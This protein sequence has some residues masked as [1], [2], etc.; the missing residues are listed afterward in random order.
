MDSLGILSI[1]GTALAVAG[2]LPE[3]WKLIYDKK[4]NRNSPWLWAVWLLGLWCSLLYSFLAAKGPLVQ[5]NYV[6]HVVLCGAT[7]ILNMCLTWQ[8]KKVS[9]SPSDDFSP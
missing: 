1:V 8:E 3:L 2:Y 4:P 6:A 5:A 7:A 9:S